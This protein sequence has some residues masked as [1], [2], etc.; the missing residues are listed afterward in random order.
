MARYIALQINNI[1][2]NLARFNGNSAVRT[3]ISGSDQLRLTFHSDYRGEA[4]GFGLTFQ[5][6]RVPEVASSFQSCN[7][8][9]PL[10]FSHEYNH[11]PVSL[12]ISQCGGWLFAR[13]GNL[14]SPNF[15]LFYP[16]TTSCAWTLQ[17]KQPDV[18]VL[19]IFPGAGT[20]NSETQI[21]A[22]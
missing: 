5:P 20:G 9:R 7:R 18:Q 19:K 12:F 3:I 22:H 4:R 15:P 21:P 13:E 14:S 6:V 17:V 1:A 10:F 2:I 8:C 16:P 11:F